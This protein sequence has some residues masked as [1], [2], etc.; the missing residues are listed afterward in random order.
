MTIPTSAAIIGA[1]R[2]SDLLARMVAL[3]ATM[4]LS[5]GEVEA[6]RSKLACAEVDDDGSTIASVYEYAVSQPRYSAGEDPAAVTDTHILRAL[7]TLN[8]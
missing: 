5:Q 8:D 6:A 2:D 3:G 1:S 4:G 7:G